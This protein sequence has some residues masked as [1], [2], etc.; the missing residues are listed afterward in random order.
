MTGARLLT[1]REVAER[2]H[3]S[4]ETVLRRARAG[5][6]PAFRI[7]TNALRFDEAELDRWLEAHRYTR[8]ESK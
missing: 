3:L 1:T 6:L 5:L 8:N 4:P 2:L 7:A